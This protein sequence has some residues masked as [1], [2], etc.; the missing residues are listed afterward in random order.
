MPNL[1]TARRISSLRS[2]DAKTIGEITK[3]N[4]DFLME[5]TFD[6]DIQAKK[7]YIYDFYHDDQPDKN[8]NMTYDNTTK[9][10]IDAKFIINSYQSIDKDQVPYYLQFRPSQKYSFS[11]ND[12][13]YYYETDY[14]ERYLADFPIGLFVDI[15]DD[16]KIYHKWLI[17]GREIANQFRKYL[18]LPC[19]YNLTWIEKTGQ[20]R[21]K[22]KMWGVLR[23]QNSY[24]TG[25]YRDH[26][27]AHPDNQD[28]IWFP[29]NPIT[30]KFWYNDD[31]SK[32]MRLIISAPTEHPLAWSVTK[33]ENTKPVGIQKLTIYQDFWDE[34][35]D[36]IERDEN[37][38]IIGMYADY[39]DSSVIPV[40]PSTPGEIAGINKKIIASST[41]VKVGG[42]YKLFTIKILDEDHNDISDQYKGGEFTWK[43]S[44]ENNE[45]SDHVSWSK[46]GCKYNQIKM[47]FINDRNYLGKLLLISC[48]ISLN[49]NIIRVAE[50]F[51]ITV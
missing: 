35:R 42:S 28:K 40:E 32:T 33:I 7:C 26:Y 3:E 21:I 19:D 30:E 18:I 20:N 10:P 36:Y 47:K 15:A 1:S 6:H 14:H 8:Q 23:N 12:D 50:N 37:G 43:C 13:L 31:V 51:E 41:N 39:Y 38:K 16:N 27:F 46:S 17:V 4:S 24:T 44:V 11:E 49:N 48:D 2:N 25:K 45:L 29:L 9:T 5:Q 34:H 22:R